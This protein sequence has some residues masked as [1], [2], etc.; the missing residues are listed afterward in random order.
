MESGTQRWF[1]HWAIPLLVCILGTV[2]LCGGFLY[3]AISVGV[4]TPNAPP[5]IAAREARDLW[6]ADVVFLVGLSVLVVGIVLFGW[7]ALVRRAHR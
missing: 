5:A 3:G 4:P 1:S 7:V 2:V 6:I